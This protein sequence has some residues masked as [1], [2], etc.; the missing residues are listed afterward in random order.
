LIASLLELMGDWQ[1]CYVWR[2]LGSWPGPATVNR[3]R[4][5][6][7]VELRILQGLGLPLGTADVRKAC[8][9]VQ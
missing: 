4:L 2:H 3:L 6:D 7:V 1:T 5:N 8:A 9:Q